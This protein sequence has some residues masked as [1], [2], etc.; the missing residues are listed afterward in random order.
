MCD[1][2]FGI[3]QVILALAPKGIPYVPA[4]SNH[5][6]EGCQAPFKADE[7]PKEAATRGRPLHGSRHP[8]EKE[9]FRGLV[10]I[11]LKQQLVSR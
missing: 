9:T 10:S 11:E 1:R 2:L 8:L 5:S 6:L 4:H 3:S 7:F